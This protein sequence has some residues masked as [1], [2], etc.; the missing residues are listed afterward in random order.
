MAISLSVIICTHNPRQYSLERVMSALQ[1]Q[2]LPRERWELLL[3]DNHSEKNLSEAWD[4]TWQTNARHV[5]E[6]QLGLTPARLRGIREAKGEL[7]LFIDDDNILGP[8]FL[9]RAVGI[10]ARCPH[11]GAFGAGR[12]E[13]EFETPP[14]P[15]LVPKLSMLALRTVS[16]ELWSNNPKD[17]ACYPWGAGLCVTRQTADYYPELVRRLNAQEV[18]DRRGKLLF[19]GGDDL[20]SWAA[21]ACGK[22]FGIF[23]ELSITHLIFAQRLNQ[24]YF[25]R[26][27]QAHR[28]SQDILAY[29][30]T[31]LRHRRISLA[32]WIRILL[33]GLKNGKFSM[34]CQWAMAQG[35]NGAVNFIAANG[36]QPLSQ[37][38]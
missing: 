19:S 26:L 27:I 13:P 2:T 3:V 28:F 1:A 36:L 35:Q 17:S 29:L 9:E 4:M 31:G 20:F 18:L 14:P 25:V 33:H 16:T 7:L 38:K 6:D 15:E 21:A 37:R 5:R 24:P 8:E 34:Q 32:Q 23:P 22:G 10:A 11:L 12:L 30:L